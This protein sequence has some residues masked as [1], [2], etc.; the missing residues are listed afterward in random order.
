MSKKLIAVNKKAT[1]LANALDKACDAMNAFSS[2]CRDADLPF[3][4][5]DDSRILLLQDMV[6]YAS[7]LRAVHEKQ[8][9]GA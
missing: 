8:G 6:E 9:G 5:A 4:G 2:A 1:A 3:K 7:Y